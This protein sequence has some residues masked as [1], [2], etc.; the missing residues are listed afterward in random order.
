MS[1]FSIIK[2]TQNIIIYALNSL[3]SFQN[4][5]NQRLRF[6]VE[7][8]DTMHYSTTSSPSQFTGSVSI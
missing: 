6:Q 7:L 5:L 8:A 3:K 1:I 4:D 2:H